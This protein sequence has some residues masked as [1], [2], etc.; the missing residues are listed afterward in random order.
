MLHA[1]GKASALSS[2]SLEVQK[3]IE[4]SPQRWCG[5]SEVQR[6][7]PWSWESASEQYTHWTVDMTCV[8]TQ[9]ALVGARGRSLARGEKQPTPVFGFGQSY[10]F[11]RATCS[12]SPSHFPL[13]DKGRRAAKRGHAWACPGAQLNYAR[14]PRGRTLADHQQS[15]YTNRPPER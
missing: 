3:V 11:P 2:F 10:L 9:A 15:V 7:P 1:G 5:G 12:T 14:P 6:T 4:Q 8:S 13:V